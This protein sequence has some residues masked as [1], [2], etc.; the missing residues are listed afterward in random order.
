MRA[1]AAVGCL[2]GLSLVGGSAV[3]GGGGP[4]CQP[5]AAVGDVLAQ[6]EALADTVLDR[7]ASREERTRLIEKALERFPGDLFLHRASQDLVLQRA[8]V[9]AED[10][11]ALEEAYKARLDDHPDDP[12]WIYLYARSVP[13]QRDGERL[14]LW[15][16][17]LSIDPS[18][19]PAHMELTMLRQFSATHKDESEARQHARA[20]TRLCPEGLDLL[21]YF[22]E[23]DDPQREEAAKRARAVLERRDDP[24]AL[25][26]YWRLW[27]LEFK[28]VPPTE[29]DAVRARVKADVERLRAMRLED[30]PSWWGVLAS[31]YELA[32]EPAQKEAV[33]RARE[34]RFPCSFQ[35]AQARQG[36]WRKEHPYPQVGDQEAWSDR[37][38]ALYDASAEWVRQCP[39]SL[40]DWMDRFHAT[41]GVKDLP[42]DEVGTV[43][44]RF[45]EL[46]ARPDRGVMTSPSPYFQVAQIYVGRRFRVA[47]VEALVRQ[48]VAEED[49]RVAQMEASNPPE[50]MRR[51]LADQRRQIQWRAKSLE[52][53]AAIVQGRAEAA[54]AAVAEMEALLGGFADVEGPDDDRMRG[55]WGRELTM[56]K[57]D[58]AEAEGH[59][60]D[61]LML[62][63]SVLESA[64]DDPRAKTQVDRL[65]E[66]LGGTEEGRAAWKHLGRSAPKAAESASPWAAKDAPLAEFELSDLAG[67]TW[68]KQDL[69]GRVAFVNLW[70]TSCGPCMAELPQVQKLHERL[71]G[72]TDALVLTLNLDENTGV[73][74]PVLKKNGY[75]FPVLLA[76][77]WA[78]ET[79]DEVVI[80]RNWIVDR[81]GRLR[82][83]QIGFNFLSEGW[84]DDVLERLTSVADD[85]TEPRK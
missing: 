64:P 27:A 70:A 11:A 13:Y 42:L 58:R 46:W 79:L 40:V 59:R 65:W 47:Q 71:Q 41:L 67:K 35:S 75:G 17:A 5:D 8:E 45:L 81:D 60:L 54:G 52:A 25:R 32:G 43:V 19:A 30:R 84:V 6:H 61:A 39:D 63:L 51:R 10:R 29:H 4:L 36:R 34:E 80:P 73:I 31:G 14:A 3:A 53:R 15:N 68:S 1:A 56:V 24:Q 38:R 48:G 21:S 49:A 33:E 62:A 28:I 50:P 74:L 9:T 23:S 12:I 69:A 76:S 20:Y 37:S 66:E 78:E 7:A 18:F 57:S 85:A 44:D 72:R 83:E 77:D 26:S 22:L 2:V 82:Y 55:Q 16:R